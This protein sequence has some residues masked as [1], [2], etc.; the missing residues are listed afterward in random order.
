MQQLLTCRVP[1]RPPERRSRASQGRGQAPHPRA[2]A[3][4]L[5]RAPQQLQQG[6]RQRAQLCEGDKG[7]SG[8]QRWAGLLAPRPSPGNPTDRIAAGAAHT[9]GAPGAHRHPR[10]PGTGGRRRRRAGRCL[11]AAPP[12]GPRPRAPC[13]W[14]RGWWGPLRGEEEPVH[15]PF[16]VLAPKALPRGETGFPDA[17]GDWRHARRKQYRAFAALSAG[18]STEGS[19]GTRRSP[20]ICS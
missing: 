1:A 9:A 6:V 17:E 16:G 13:S 2:R 11:P 12:A 5:L 7:V 15:S 10:A 18:R 14:A 4:Q 3:E 20:F 19:I 8:A